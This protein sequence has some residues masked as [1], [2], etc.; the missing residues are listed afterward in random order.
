M[1]EVYRAHD[2]KLGRGG[3][4]KALPH[5]VA[6]DPERLMRFR[7]GERE[8]QALSQLSSA[9]N[10]ETMAGQILGT[11]PYMSPEQARGKEVD[12]RADIWAFGCVLYELLA[13]KRAFEGQKLSE[14]IAAIL[15]REPDWQALPART[16]ARIRE[17]LR[18]CLEKD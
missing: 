1:G 9:T 10:L 6:G 8:R 7:P 16:P 2:R 5:E 18:S 15:E 13:G 17:L 14:T 3:A 4:I 12:Q 11:P